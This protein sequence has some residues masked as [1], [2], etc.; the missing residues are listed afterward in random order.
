M[1]L[2]KYL[3]F[4]LLIVIIGTSIYIATLDGNYDIN[5]SRIIKVPVEV[6]FNEVNDFKKWEKWNPW[7]ELDTTIIASFPEST[8]GV[9][10][11]YTWTGADGN[12]S[13][14][15]LSIIP[16]KEIIQQINFGIGSKPEVYWKFNTI[17]KNTEVTWGMKG[18]SGFMEKAY[19]LTQGGIEENLTPMHE[20][21]LELLEQQLLKELEKHTIEIKGIVD[22]GGG[23]YLYQTMACKVENQKAKMGELFPIIMSYMAEHKIEASGKPFTLTHKWDEVNN[24]T[25]FSACIPIKERVITTGA[26]LTGFLKPQK[27]FK[28]ILKGD[29][30]FLYNAWEEAFNALNE[31]GFTEKKGGE[32]FEIYTVSP[33]DTANPTKWVSEIYIPIN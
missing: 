5:K 14:E 30:K 9:G 3:F 24:T 6:V 11:S 4:L 26:I 13:M 2:L 28:T 32:P 15:T 29:S 22:Y 25:I 23:Y 33:H 7:Y 1:K 31:Q 10:A 20:R 27:T 21:G 18:K 8:S 12:G 17:D 16:N 19:W